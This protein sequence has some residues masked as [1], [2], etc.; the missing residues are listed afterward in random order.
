MSSLAT[1]IN[2]GAL[3]ASNYAN[4]S[5]KEFNNSIARISSGFV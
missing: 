5:Q 3:M 4:K 1:A 2:T